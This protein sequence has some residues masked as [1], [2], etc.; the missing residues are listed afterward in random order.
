M[1]QHA[2][3]VDVTRCIEC[4]S[5]VVAC[6]QENGLQTGDWWLRV[7]QREQLKGHLVRYYNDTVM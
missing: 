5:C 4:K 3:L 6:K 2:M 7:W 1:S